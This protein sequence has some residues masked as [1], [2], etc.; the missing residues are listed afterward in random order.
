MKGPIK[1]PMP[2]V[3][4]IPMKYSKDVARIARDRGFLDAFDCP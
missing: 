3:R 2:R 4:Q 1:N